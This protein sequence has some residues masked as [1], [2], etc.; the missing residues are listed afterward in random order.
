MPEV[1]DYPGVSGAHLAVA[2]NYSS[3]LLQGPPLCDELL[4]LVEHMFTD[5]E[6]DI[7]QHLKPLRFK[8]SAGLAATTGRPRGE[9]E[10]VLKRLALDKH[11]ILSFGKEGRER[12][13]IMPIVPG[14]F[15]LTLMRTSADSVTP[16]DRRFASLFEDLFST[17]YYLD[18]IDKPID[19]VRYLP[20]GEF[21]KTEPMALPSDRLEEILER[22]DNFAVGV[23][24]CRLTKNMSG[25]GC[26]RML[27]TC[28]AVGPWAPV[29]VRRGQMREVS[30]RDV[31]EI[32][33]Q[34]ESEG[35]VTWMMNEESGR[36]SS[37]L[38]SCCGCCCDALRSITEFN[39]P[40][41]I[42]PP[43]FMPRI[44]QE[45]CNACGKCVKACPMGALRLLEEGGQNR[46]VTI[47][48][49]CIGCGLCSVTC[50]Q[51][52]IS[53]QEVPDYRKPPGGYATYF[54][55]YLPNIVHNVWKVWSARRR[56]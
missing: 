1:G 33:A 53:M 47:P 52:A 37:A 9:V 56:E 12:Y 29:M 20:V 25:E 18:Y 27:E 32:K 46:L 31:L 21:I 49:R 50:P 42:A 39:T 30:M 22:Y 11:V 35:L 26:G 34:A 10:T 23:C 51:G 36:F 4:A 48:E 19:S 17:G 15:E 55:R 40:G 6:A 54:A 38:C 44:N 16:W 8:N 2:K 14:T 3:P 24:Q 43:H 5:E 45:S 41:I 28:T 13:L 7:V